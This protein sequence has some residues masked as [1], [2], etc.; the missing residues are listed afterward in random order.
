M[1]LILKRRRILGLP[2]DD[3]EEEPEPEPDPEP[4]PDPE[5]DPEPEEEDPEEED[6]PVLVELGGAEVLELFP[7]LVEL[8]GEEVVGGAG[9]GATRAHLNEFDSLLMTSSVQL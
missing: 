5:E 3:P 2:E 1:Y 4:D 6:P 9:G 7:L 8:G